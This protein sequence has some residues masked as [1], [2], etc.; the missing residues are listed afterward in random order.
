[1]RY[2]VLEDHCLP[3]ITEKIAILV[4]QIAALVPYLER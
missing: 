1:M 2:V 3:D 4:R